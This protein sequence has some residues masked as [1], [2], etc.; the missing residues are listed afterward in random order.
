MMYNTLMSSKHFIRLG[1][2][3]AL[4]IPSIAVAY[5]S[6]E[7]TLTDDNNAAF[8]FSPPPHGG[9]AA[10]DRVAEQQASAAA[11]RAEEQAK[12]FVKKTSSSA[13]SASS[14]H[15]AAV[16]EVSS[17]DATLTTDETDT[18]TIPTDEELR[19]QRILERVKARQIAE[20]A[21]GS[22]SDAALH[23]GAPLIPS[24]PA[25]DVSIALLLAVAGWTMYR[26]RQSEKS[27]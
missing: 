24:G 16:E 19:D 27:A 6:P 4:L 10:L 26:A 3:A 17:D 11:R 15:A 12:L 22:Q 7:E 5:T 9:A 25:T 1:L 13:S 18:S 14:M 2:V 21:G 20:E 23:S 8:F